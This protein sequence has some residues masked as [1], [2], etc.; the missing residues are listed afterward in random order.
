L[1][2][3]LFEILL[4][5]QSLYWCSGEYGLNS[6]VLFRSLGQE[7]ICGARNEVLPHKFFRCGLHVRSFE[8]GQRQDVGDETG[9]LV[10]VFED[11]SNEFL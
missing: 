4:A 5:P 1:K 8:P 10:C 7:A 2:T 3:G 11:G 9:E 6:D